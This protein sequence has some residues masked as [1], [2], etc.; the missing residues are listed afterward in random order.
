MTLTE[1]RIA[2][3]TQEEVTLPA[4]EL[5]RE[6]IREFAAAVRNDNPA[7]WDVATAKRLGYT[8]L[9]M[10]PT[11]LALVG[12]KWQKE[13]FQRLLP[14][15]DISKILH[16]EQKLAFSKPILAGSELVMVA[17]VESIKVVAGMNMIVVHSEINT[18]GEKVA[19]IWGTFVNKED[20]QVDPE[21]ANIAEGVMKYGAV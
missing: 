2:E 5:G 17:K 9:V 11:M 14:E 19:D 6:K 16:V 13:I 18:S 4:Y 20:V 10:P 3:I 1:K 7:F 21:V 15:L 12:A 8:D